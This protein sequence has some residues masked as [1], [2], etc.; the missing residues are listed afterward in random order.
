MP[1]AG[2]QAARRDAELARVGQRLVPRGGGVRAASSP[3]AATAQAIAQDP[4]DHPS[5]SALI[6]GTLYPGG[7][8]AAAIRRAV[9]RRTNATKHSV[10][11]TPIVAIASHIAAW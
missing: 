2:D 11:A 10:C 7:A 4:I 8:V 1:R 5:E 3:Q 6:A 9:R